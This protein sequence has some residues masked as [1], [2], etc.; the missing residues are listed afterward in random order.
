[1]SITETITTFNTFN[2]FNTYEHHDVKNKFIDKRNDK[3][4]VQQQE[5]EVITNTL[6]KKL[7][8]ENT[9]YSCGQLGQ[10]C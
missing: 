8:Y 4:N 10:G 9:T 6:S 7:N 5:K 2:T 3:N 1:M